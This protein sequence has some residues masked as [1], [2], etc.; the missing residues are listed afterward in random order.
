M[1]RVMAVEHVG[2]NAAVLTR[3]E[4]VPELQVDLPSLG[5]EV[6]FAGLAQDF[7]VQR[8]AHRQVESRGARGDPQRAAQQQMALVRVALHIQADL[9][10][11]RGDATHRMQRAAVVAAVAT[12]LLQSRRQL[13]LLVQIESGTDM[14]RLRVE[15]AVEGQ[16]TETA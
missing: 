11:F 14:H 16:R 3:G 5:G 8:P 4:G 6:Y 15:T 10:L 9:R 7:T 1:I 2:L 12:T 13:D